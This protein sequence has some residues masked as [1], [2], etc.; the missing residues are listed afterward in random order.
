MTCTTTLVS[1]ETAHD[2]SRLSNQ[3]A[4]FDFL[5]HFKHHGDRKIV[6]KA[7]INAKATGLTRNAL[8]PDRLETLKD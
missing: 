3:S 1:C 4:S 7:Q 2:L 8:F 6:K 5:E